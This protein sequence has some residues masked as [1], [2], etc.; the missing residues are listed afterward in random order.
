MAQSEDALPAP[1]FWAPGS[2]AAAP[3]PP[4]CCNTRSLN[5]ANTALRAAVGISVAAGQELRKR[6]SSREHCE[7]ERSRREGL[8]RLEP[9][10]GGEYACDVEMMGEGRTGG[11]S[12]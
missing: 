5:S 3:S 8:R 7:P 9:Q 12:T 1:M 11:R 4:S 10:W 6:R 2:L